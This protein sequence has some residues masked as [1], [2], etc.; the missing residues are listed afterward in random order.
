MRLNIPHSDKK[1]VVVIGGGFA[2][3]HLAARLRGSG[4]QVIVLDKENYHQF[5]PLLYQVATAGLEPS[6]MAFPLREELSKNPDTYFRMAE[7]ASVNAAHKTVRSSIGEIDYDFLVIATGV[8]TAY[9]GMENIRAN[10]LPMKSV[11]EALEIRNHI[12]QNMEES[13]TDPD[14]ALR[15]IVVAGGGATGVEIAGALADMKRLSARKK[16]NENGSQGINIYLIDGSDRLLRNLSPKSSAAALR[17]LTDMGVKV[18]LNTPVTDYVDNRVSL[19]NGDSIATKNLIWTSGVTG[20]KITG[21]PDAC[22]GRGCR[23]L[24]DDT[25]KVMGLDD[26]FA[27]G[28]IAMNTTNPLPQVAQVA[29]QQGRHLADNLLSI[30]RNEEPTPFTYRDKGNMATIGR[31]RAVLETRRFQTHGFVAWVAWLVVHL[32]SLLGTKNKLVTSL[33]WVWNY[34]NYDQSLGLIFRKRNKS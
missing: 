2:G 33:E 15:N 6:A 3:L 13:F 9:F 10:A 31:N 34:M 1:R 29:I 19:G 14:P 18:V 4:F 24:V 27:V 20:H 30:T 11:D 17:Y 8:D 25:N 28:D 26:V 23:L 12:F 21:I 16:R 5:S 22:Y 7:V 32:F